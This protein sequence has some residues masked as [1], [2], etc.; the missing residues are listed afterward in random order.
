MEP[1][2]DPSR[3]SESTVVRRPAGNSRMTSSGSPFDGAMLLGGSP[4]PLPHYLTER[5]CVPSGAGTWLE[6]DAGASH[7]CWFGRL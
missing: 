1:E 2:P 4:V 5:M 7:P 6:R 3:G